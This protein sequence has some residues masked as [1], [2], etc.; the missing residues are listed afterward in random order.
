MYAAERVFAAAPPAYVVALL[1]QLFWIPLRL[2]RIAGRD[3]AHDD[4][5]IAVMP[6]VAMVL[7]V[8][9]SREL[10]RRGRGRVRAGMIVTFVSNVLWVALI[11]LGT[12]VATVDREQYAAMLDW[13]MWLTSGVTVLGVIGLAIAAGRGGTLTSAILIVLTSLVVV[14]AASMSIARLIG[15]GYIFWFYATIAS[16][17]AIL[18]ISLV[19]AIARQCEAPVRDHRRAS[20]SFSLLAWLFAARAAFGCVMAVVGSSTTIVQMWML[21]IEGVLLAAISLVMWDI[22]QSRL[23]MLPRFL[24]HLALAGVFVTTILIFDII[25][26]VFQSG[27]SDWYGSGHFIALRA[28]HLAAAA[29]G[30]G[31]L[32]GSVLRYAKHA[33]AIRWSVVTSAIVFGAVT[34]FEFI[35]DRG[36]WVCEAIA[37]TAL[38]VVSRVAARAL[39]DD[40]VPTT[41]D[42][43]G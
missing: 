15:P 23:P 14:S 43:F 28:W 16:V 21:G 33:P 6:L 42:V 12:A 1:L 10:A 31:L 2:L 11:V 32:V 4:E 19:A 27:L 25:V 40:P 5:L 38:I 34:A 35:S 20:R 18:G 13:L 29:V 24:P 30:D 39:A 41:A 8:G 7:M 3:L 26:W 17:H 22:A 37:C 9:A 36:T